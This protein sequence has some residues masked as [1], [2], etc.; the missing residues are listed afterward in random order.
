VV[1][2]IWASTL[3]SS[4]D[5]L[6]SVLSQPGARLVAMGKA[7]GVAVAPSGDAVLAL[8]VPPA[9]TGKTYEA[10]VIRG[11]RAEPAGLFPGRSGTSVVE[12]SQPVRTGN[13]VAVTLERAGGVR[14]PTMKPLAA[15]GKVA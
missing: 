1:L 5:P 7:G 4:S 11:T 14:Q 12:I 3:S 10:W 2:G 8:A 15:S 13:V 6:E 9:P